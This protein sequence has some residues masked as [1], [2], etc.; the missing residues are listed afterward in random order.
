MKSLEGAQVSE[1]P[2]TTSTSTVECSSGT[3]FFVSAVSTGPFFSFLTHQT[4][5]AYYLDN[6]HCIYLFYGILGQILLFA[7]I[8]QKCPYLWSQRWSCALLVRIHSRHPRI[9]SSP[10]QVPHKCP[11]SAPS[12]RMSNWPTPF[13][14]PCSATHC[15]FPPASK[16]WTS[17]FVKVHLLKFS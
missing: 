10:T 1:C 15:Y 11:T 5:M 16:P 17:K 13:E 6:C 4:I 14:D 8:K 3:G 12:C 9:L 2:R 7:H